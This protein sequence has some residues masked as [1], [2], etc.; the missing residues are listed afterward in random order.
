MLASLWV[1]T[2][3]AATVTFQAGTGAYGTT[4][5]SYI[6]GSRS[7]SD[8]NFS[9]EPWLFADLSDGDNGG[10]EVRSLVRF[11]DVVGPG[12]GQIRRGS[13]VTAATLVFTVDNEGGALG[14]HEVLEPWDVDEVS[15][16]SRGDGPWAAEGAGPPSSSTKALTELEASTDGLLSFGVQVAVREWARNPALNHGFV[17]VPLSSDGADL[18]SSASPDEAARPMLVVEYTP[19]EG[20]TGAPDDTGDAVQDDADTDAPDDN[21]EADASV[22]GGDG[23]KDGAGC[24]VV[25][26]V[27]AVGWGMWGLAVGLRRRQRS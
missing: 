1:L 15:W 27:A 18:H 7:S 9:T 3:M 4:H 26:G 2:A 8:A 6:V 25:G 23:G 11:P 12:E 14:I 5:D 17:L 21:T 24:D 13:V 22:D 19:S 20:D 16:A 10:A